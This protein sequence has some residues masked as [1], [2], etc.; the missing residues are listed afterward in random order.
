MM[1]KI[2]TLLKSPGSHKAGGR[3]PALLLQGIDKTFDGKKVLSCA[4][5]R[6]EWGEVHALVGENGAGK[7][8]IMNVATGVYAPDCGKV[9][10]DGRDVPLRNPADAIVAGIGMV[11]QHFRL[12][13]RFTVAEN[14]ALALGG[15]GRRCSI[16]EAA[17]LIEEKSGELGFSLDPN[18]RVERISVAEQQR[19]E[20]VKVLL[21]GAGIM[22]LDEPTA[23]LTQGETR[24][25]LS[26]L[27]RLA[28]AGHAVVL[29]THKLQ[30]VADHCDQITVMTQGR[31]VLDAAPMAVTTIAQVTQLAFGEVKEKPPVQMGH[32]GDELLRIE[33][34]EVGDGAVTLEGLTLSLRA[35][36]IFGIAGV[37]GNG[38]SELVACLNGLIRP[39]DGR[40]V[41]TGLDLT[42]ASPAQRRK[43][44]LRI[45]PAD[46]FD[47]AMAGDLTLSENL[48]LTS[49][50]SGR[51]GPWWRMSR[52]AMIR[53]AEKSLKDFNVLGGTPETKASLLSGGNA[54]KVLLARELSAGTRVVVAHSPVR[55]LDV[56]SVNAVL[57]LLA[58][59]A[60]EGAACLL[61]SEDLDEILHMCSSVAVLNRGRLSAPLSGADLNPTRLG[62][63]MV[64]HV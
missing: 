24:G 10:V 57:D 27:Q 38:Q 9:I 26:L 11:H 51:F 1:S 42:N 5:F 12:V 46:R 43:A 45:I 8:T 15:A 19:A 48:T 20:I 7:S 58:E 17:H 31:T 28:L 37:G 52:K 49:L 53:D 35:G 13:G 16:G 22:I 61:I 34:L 3:P 50:D 64:G 32:F 4:G 23:V 18:A 55:G 29:I 63:L 47:S 59:S 30:E 56:R 62:E 36:E 54:Q 41:L 25:L 60:K 6:L 2:K 44:G 21:L 14:V 39:L 33:D 40:I